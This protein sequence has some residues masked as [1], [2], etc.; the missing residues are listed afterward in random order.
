MKDPGYNWIQINDD[1]LK[2]VVVGNFDIS[3]KTTSVSFPVNGTWYNYFNKSSLNVTGGN[4]SIALQPGEFHVFFNKDLSNTLITSISGPAL[5]S[6]DKEA[7][8]IPNPV[9]SDMKV[10]FQLAQSG[11]VKI[12]LLNTEGKS[13]GELYKGILAA[14]KREIAVSSSDLQKTGIRPGLYT[15]LIR[16]NQAQQ[17][18]R[19]V[20]KK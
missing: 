16:S 5:P 7:R 8:V 9:T 13:M 14:G 17:A 3:A 18:L 6:L 19:F 20:Y 12:E 2:V 4:S 15:I 10:A 11:W 1:A